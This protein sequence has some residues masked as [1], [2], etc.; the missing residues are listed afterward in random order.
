[1]AV[2]L[3]HTSSGT[4]VGSTTSASWSHDATGDNLLIVVLSF[5]GN[6]SG[7]SVTYN[8]VA[9]TQIGT[10]TTCTAGQYAQLWIFKLANPATGSNTVAV[11][12]SG[13]QGCSGCSASY[14]GAGT[15]SA[16]S[17]TAGNKTYSDTI[18]ANDMIVGIMA[19]ADQPANGTWTPA[20]DVDT[21]YSGVD[22][23][24][25]C[26]ISHNT[27]TGS[28]SV[29]MNYNGTEN[30]GAGLTITSGSN[31]YSVSVSQILSVTDSLARVWSAI[32]SKSETIST[33]EQK[34][35]AWVAT[36]EQLQTVLLSD[37]VT[38][39]QLQTQTEIDQ[40]NLS[41]EVSIFIGQ[42]LSPVETLVVTDLVEIVKMLAVT[43]TE[44]MNITD[45]SSLALQM[46][47]LVAE[48]MTVTDLVTRN[49]SWSFKT[50]HGSSSDWTYKNKS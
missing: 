10:E 48:T 26:G 38:A 40:V 42:L 21:G 31:A 18:G 9:M 13:S 32:V 23:A 2:A 36:L 30:V 19:L 29:T 3:G 25:A 28:V 41:D 15:V 22:S 37:L 33:S 49:T 8:G 6:V 16:P 50:K 4:R 17:I 5:R 34:S 24:T 35:Q 46:S 44:Q 12:W 14:S 43:V 11:S 27:G 47:A 1:M 20:R 39:G 45:A 7:V